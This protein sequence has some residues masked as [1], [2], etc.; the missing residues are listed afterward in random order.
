MPTRSRSAACLL[1]LLH[2]CMSTKALNHRILRTSKAG[3]TTTTCGL[4]IDCSP[5]PYTSRAR[6]KQYSTDC[7]WS[8]QRQKHPPR[9]PGPCSSS[10]TKISATERPFTSSTLDLLLPLLK[11]P[12]QPELFL[13]DLHF[14]NHV[15]E[16]HPSHQ[17]PHRTSSKA[18]PLTE[19]ESRKPRQV[20]TG[21]ACYC[22]RPP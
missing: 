20:T 16:F 21:S 7:L 10:P 8:D 11:S 17:L 4:G 13:L 1:A 12:K 5:T 3:V 9:L 22:F 15:P 6:T 19:G 18:L 2:V 14:D